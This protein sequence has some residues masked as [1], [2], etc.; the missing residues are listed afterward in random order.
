MQDIHNYSPDQL[1]DNVKGETYVEFDIEISVTQQTLCADEEI[2][3][4]ISSKESVSK[5]DEFKKVT[6]KKRRRQ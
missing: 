5:E 4:A 2:L 6:W 1:A 3:Q